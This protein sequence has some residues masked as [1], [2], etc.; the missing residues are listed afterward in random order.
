MVYKG[1]NMD[2]FLEI[3]FDILIDIIE[4]VFARKKGKKKSKKDDVLK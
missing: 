4:V 1:V 3:V 2:D